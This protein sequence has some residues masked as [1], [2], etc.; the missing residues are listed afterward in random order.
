[1][2]RQGV[3]RLALPRLPLPIACPGARGTSLRC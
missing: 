2:P 3:P 1:M